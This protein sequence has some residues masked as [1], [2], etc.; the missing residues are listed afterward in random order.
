M[1]TFFTFLIPCLALIL[2]DYFLIFAASF[3]IPY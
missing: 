1:K 3:K 2:T